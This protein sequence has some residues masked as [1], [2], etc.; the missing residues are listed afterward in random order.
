MNEYRQRALNRVNNTS[1]NAG[2]TT[3]TYRQ[4]ALNRQQKTEEPKVEEIKVEPQTK[5]QTSFKPVNV[6]SF[7]NNN[8]PS[9]QSQAQT[10]P[11]IQLAT[12]TSPE[13]VARRKEIEDRMTELK[14]LKKEASDNSMRIGYTP[15][16]ITDFRNQ[17]KTYSDE[18]NK[19][20]DE[21]KKVGTYSQEETLATLTPEEK[22]LVDSGQYVINPTYNPYS[23][24]S[25][26]LLY[27]NATLT[28]S[29]KFE[30]QRWDNANALGKAK[31]IG[32]NIAE[33][34]SDVAGGVE[35][36]IQNATYGDLAIKEKQAWS[37]YR[38]KQDNESLAKA[39]EAT[40]A[41]ELYEATH[42]KVGTGN[43]FTKDFA[44]YIPQM[45]GQLGAGLSN[46]LGGIGVGAGTALV[47]GQLGPQVGLPEEIITVPAAAATLGKAGYV[48]GT[49]KYSYDLMAGSAYKT[50]LDMGV[51]N[52]V[53][54]ELS[55]DEAFVN[56]LIEGGGAVVDL[57][58]LGLGKLA[59]KSSLTVA[60]KLAQ[61]K[62]LQAGAA[63][64]L[65]Y[66]S[67]REE[68][69]LQER[70]SIGTEKKAAEM[71]GIE[72]EA[73]EEDDKKRIQE[74]KRAGG[75]IAL[76]SG[77]GN[78]AG[79]VVTNKISEKANTNS[80]TQKLPNLDSKTLAQ[81]AEIQKNIANKNQ[82]QQNVSELPTSQ[83]NVAREL[84]TMAS[85]Q[86]ML[87][88]N[89]TQGKTVQTGNMEQI[90]KNIEK[91]AQFSKK[92]DV[93]GE[94][95]AFSMPKNDN[96]GRQLTTEQQEFFKDSKLKD[97]KGNLIAYYHGTENGGFNRFEY[98]KQKGAGKALGEGFYFTQSKSQAQ[99]YASTEES[100]NKSRELLGLP[101]KEVTPQVYEVYLNA[102][103]PLYLSEYKGDLVDKADYIA[104]KYLNMDTKNDMYRPY[105]DYAESKLKT[106]I[107]MIDYIKSVSERSG[108]TTAEIF[109][110]LGYDALVD[111]KFQTVVFNSNQIKN[112]DNTNPT[113][114]PD[115]RYF[116]SSESSKPY[117]DLDIYTSRDNK[118]QAKQTKLTDIQNAINDIVPVKTGKFRQNA[119]G[120]YKTAGE[121]IRLKQTKDIPVALHELT[122]HLDKKYNLSSSDKVSN[123]LAKIAVVG[124]NATK[125]T[126]IKEGV[127]EFGRYYMT[128]KEYAK[129]IA[130]FYYDAF[131]KALNNDPEMK[132]KVENIRQMVTDYLDQSPINRLSS[133]IDYGDEQMSLWG[134]AKEGIIKTAHNFRKNFVDDLDPL[135][136]IVNEIAGDDKL[137]TE[138]DAY[139][140]LRLNNGVTGK[141]QVA[142]EYGILDKNG[143]KISKSLKEI[144]E[145][146]ANNQKEFIAYLTALRAEDLQ[147]RGIE[148]G[149]LPSDVNDVI[150]M[151]KSNETFNQAAKELYNFQNKILETTLVDSGIITKD[152]LKAY[153]KNNPHYVPFYRV[154]DENFKQSKD[155][156]SK[157]PMKIKGSTRDIINPLESIIKNTYSYMQMAERNDTYKTLFDM[158]NRYDGTGKWFD[159]VPTD[160]IGQTVTAE[161]VKSILEQLNLG[162]EEVNYNEIFTTIFKPANNQKG[163]I[164]TVMEKGK[165]VHYEIND[166]ELYDILSPT[167]KG[168]NFIVKMLAPASKAL[169][170]GATHTPEFVLRNPIRDTQEAGI[171]SKNGFIPVVDTMIGIFN[172]AGR[173][174][175]Y[176]K[177]L[178]SGGS[179]STYTNAQRPVLQ[180]T[181]KGLTE[182]VTNES[183]GKKLL[184]NIGNTV[185][186]PLR[187]YLDVAGTISN[188]AE[189]GTRVGEFRRALKQGK[190]EKEAALDSREITLD[191]S[192]GGKNAKDINKVV[193]F[194]NAEVQGLDKMITS[195]KDRPVATFLKGLA[196]TTLPAILLRGLQDEEKLEKVPQWE[197]DE[198]FIVF[199]GDT[200][201]KIPKGQGLGQIFG[202][203]PERAIDYLRTNDFEAFD[204]LMQRLVT[205]YV[206]I[207]STTS[208]FPNFFLPLI[209]NSANY[210]FFRQ[211]PI[212]SQSLQNRSPRYQYDE[213]TSTIAKTIG[214]KLN[215]SPKKVD[216]LISGYF[217]N[218]GKDVANLA[219]GPIEWLN[220][221]ENKEYQS[222][223][224]KLKKIPLVKGFVAGNTASK[225]LDKFYE[226]KSKASTDYTDA[227]FKY[228]DDKIT[229]TEQK[230]LN[231][232]KDVNSLYNT[233]YND[234]KE[235]DE[236]IDEVSK[237][238][239]SD[240][241]KKTKIEQLNKE[242]NKIAE[243]AEEDAKKLKAKNSLLTEA[244]RKN[245][246]PKK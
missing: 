83:E 8:F 141:V 151:Y 137:M 136:K 169:R 218:L 140:L 34:A 44:Q 115:I 154:M 233:A 69:G 110:D 174:D 153:N 216:N 222:D 11:L 161:D 53:A 166:K 77:L 119:Y 152:A 150:E 52:D 118:S 144:L 46:A 149:L 70:V 234:I 223:N 16:Q 181:L 19:L 7:M 73:T 191:F 171:Y 237:G 64:G 109:K 125:Q 47:A 67:E 158:A 27:K 210:S 5:T 235:I 124:K 96:Q 107:P 146:V 29:Q 131:E 61:N 190:T 142:L 74:A 71:L 15:E 105:K 207:D 122:H 132:A 91:V 182:G 121:L 129:E 40:K 21:L 160:M 195:F 148:T 117:M 243:K 188:V 12:E 104:E 157:K 35:T 219:G 164:V 38:S 30:Q 68:E 231:Y 200:P 199:F 56:S 156:K 197:K 147:S 22:K 246:L 36:T 176:Y 179:G 2:S 60:Q 229:A 82:E 111:G 139:K 114:N 192:R 228:K 106:A 175:L 170:V 75:N 178:Q 165:P 32:S 24:G 49:A 185:K 128:D 201:I 242:K 112:V 206:P 4:R 230:L 193:A 84:P 173:S 87:P 93:A 145:P 167:I 180:K 33:K 236:Q 204:G 98:G 214:N 134:K 239:G 28:S 240:N 31:I 217:G 6:N 211:Q 123:E 55:G 58:T 159:K 225:S 213:N 126:A 41:R 244:E 232:Y 23:A 3:S 238:K 113:E 62:L 143:Q 51:P 209:E 18:Y 220:G 59:S 187:T 72:R 215:V 48:A 133:N 177:W 194:F 108:K 65:N 227:K 81:M 42:K 76:I 79:N 13:K 203:I 245:K 43:A 99:T 212:V 198:F 86:A 90:S 221:E 20:N 92:T 95:P 196:Y 80:E 138:Q 226:S 66:L 89:Q 45:T 85:Q 155:S 39:E 135:K 116:A 37:E 168:D 10:Q 172:V 57:I 189:E 14:K 26:K 162:D 100:V 25:E 54:I 205:S 102:K 163:N 183:G 9:I 127:A 1:G 63:Y 78:V 224:A 103:N 241:Y 186:H 17:Y 88:T 202:T 97:E 101:K 130:P 120:I 184:K 94:K 50:L 208:I